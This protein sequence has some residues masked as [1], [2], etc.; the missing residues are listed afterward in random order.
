M[1]ALAC[2]IGFVAHIERQAA[3][4]PSPDDGRHVKTMAT[5]H[6]ERICQIECTLAEHSTPGL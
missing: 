6:H 5:S 1:F 2:F 4:L 3:S